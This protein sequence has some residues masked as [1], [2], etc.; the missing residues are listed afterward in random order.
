MKIISQWH[1]KNE[2][3]W[4]IAIFS[5]FGG[6]HH[7]GFSAFGFVFEWEKKSLIEKCVCTKRTSDGKHADGKCPIHGV[8]A[9]IHEFMLKHP[10]V[11]GQ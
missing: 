1:F 8:E 4:G 3:V 2:S 11:P 5:V 10:K 9:C 6:T 7:R